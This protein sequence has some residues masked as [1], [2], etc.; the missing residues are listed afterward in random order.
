MEE[1]EWDRNEG[2]EGA[3]RREAVS[4]NEERGGMYCN[5]FKCDLRGAQDAVCMAQPHNVARAQQS[6]TG[7]AHPSSACIACVFSLVA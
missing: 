6:D 7:Q 5:L 1:R 3:K 4:N 2:H